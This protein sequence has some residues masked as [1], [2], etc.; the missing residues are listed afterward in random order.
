MTAS[1]TCSP[2]PSTSIARTGCMLHAPLP[3]PP[4]LHPPHPEPGRLRGGARE[5]QAPPPGDSGHG[6]DAGHA[7]PPGEGGELRTVPDGSYVA[8]TNKR[9]LAAPPNAE[10]AELSPHV[11]RGRGASMSSVTPVTPTLYGGSL[12]LG[13]G[14]SMRA[15]STPA[16]L[17]CTTSCCTV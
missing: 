5:Q 1:A 7:R 13:L 6:E 10:T 11:T 4:V 12:M 15:S 3:I 8:R 9:D 16:G 14:A 2:P 17:P